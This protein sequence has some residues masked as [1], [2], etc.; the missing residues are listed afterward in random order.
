MIVKHKYRFY[1][2]RYDMVS[3]ICDKLREGH[4]ICT[5][6]YFIIEAV[7]GTDALTYS[8][9]NG[10]STRGIFSL[11]EGD[12]KLLVVIVP[13][14]LLDHISSEGSLIKVDNRMVAKDPVSE[15]HGK[16]NSSCL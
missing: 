5:T 15:L 3:K 7:V 11:G 1:W 9:E 16:F 10:E 8:S 2:Q 13:G 6:R 12:Y 4:G 14:L